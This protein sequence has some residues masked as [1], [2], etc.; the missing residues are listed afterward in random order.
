MKPLN[1]VVT[2]WSVLLAACLS[3]TSC[4]NSFTPRVAPSCY[5]GKSD[6][7]LESA[8]LILYR[9]GGYD[10]TMNQWRKDSLNGVP[11]LK[12]VAFTPESGR[13]TRTSD[14][15]ALSSKSGIVRRFRVRREGANLF[16]TGSIGAVS[17]LKWISEDPVMT[18]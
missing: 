7:E 1:K 5:E 12:G 13:W 17:E 14:E 16:L 2:I 11:L 15:I 6:D 18:R 3:L 4:A 10:L 8:S 9:F